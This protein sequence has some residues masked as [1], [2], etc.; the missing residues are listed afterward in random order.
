MSKKIEEAI[1]LPEQTGDLKN[2]TPALVIPGDSPVSAAP[3]DGTESADAPKAGGEPPRGPLAAPPKKGGE[4]KSVYHCKK[5]LHQ[6]PAWIGRCPNCGAYQT[7]AP[8]ASP[9]KSSFSGD[10][11]IISDIEII[12]EHR[13]P[14]GTREFDRVLNGGLVE[15]A[16]ILIA[17]EPGKGKSTLA[18]QVGCALSDAAFDPCR[19]LYVSGEETESQ[20]KQRADRIA[21]EKPKNMILVSEVDIEKIEEH[22]R[23]YDPDVMFIDSIQTLR[24]GEGRAGSVT[25]V[26]DVTAMLVNI[27]KSR[28]MTTVI[29]GH[30]NSDGDI[31]GPKALEHLVD[32]VLTFDEE[33]S[34]EIRTLRCLKNRFGSTTEVGIFRMHKGGLSSVD[35]PSE[36]LLRGKRGAPGSSLACAMIRPG[37]GNGSRAMLVE[38]QA[39]YGAPSRSPKLVVSGYSK[40]RLDMI[41]AIMENRTEMFGPQGDDPEHDIRLTGM[42]LYLNVAGGFDVEE[43]A[44]DLPVAMAIASARMNVPLLPGTV[45]WGE[46]GLTGEVRPEGAFEE[47]VKVCTA[48]GF[49][50]V[51]ASE[52]GEKI[53]TINDALLSFYAMVENVRPEHE[54]PPEGEEQEEPGEDDE[55]DEDGE[56]EG[57]EG[58]EDGEDDGDEDGE[59]GDEDGEDDENEDESD[60]G[61]EDVS[62]ESMVAGK[63]NRVD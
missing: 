42:D 11:K 34:S 3:A 46:L 62:S 30:V 63:E 53:I 51:V 37:K 13:V 38:V 52:M 54:P 6:T 18:L 1:I 31:A 21:L 17:G 22:V 16:V 44:L 25:V 9:S 40:T 49:K 60:D 47:R 41:L 15:G 36:H 19:V 61:L 7:M 32:T 2:T 57:A 59:D 33:R 48:L 26:Q 29:I 5:C 55:E 43:S 27:T 14:S 10:P 4:R 58:D 20:I 45:S 35:D 12:K 39:L 50:N 8:G 23:K 56:D 24:Y 28:S